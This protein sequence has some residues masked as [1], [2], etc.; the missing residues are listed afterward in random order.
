MLPEL[1]C[2]SAGISRLTMQSRVGRVS[3]ISTTTVQALGLSDEAKLGDETKIVR[4]DGSSII[5]EI[6]AMHGDTITVLPEDK[7]K[8]LSIGDRVYLVG[9][10]GIFP[11]ESWLGRV[12]DPR[13]RPLDGRPLSNGAFSV[14]LETTPPP[15]ALRR[16]LGVRKASGLLAMDTV[17]PVV[18]GQ[19]M[20]LFAGSGVGKSMM[21]GRL[22]QSM[23]AD[24]AVVAL[25]G[26]RGREVQEFVRNTL[27][28]SGMTRSV[29]VAAT[30]D[31]PALM[32]RKCIKT[33][34]AVAEYFRDAGQQVLFLADSITRFAEAHREIATAAGEPAT[35]RGFPA[36]TS[37]QIMQLCER[38]GPGIGTSGDITAIMTVLVEGGDFD[39]PVADIVRGV[40]DGHVVLSRDIAERGRYPAI[41][42]LRSVS[43]SLPL[44]ASESE[45]QMITEVRT[46][47]GAYERSEALVRS[48]LYS[49]GSDPVLDRAVALW[50]KIDA[51]LGE[52]TEE[53]IPESFLKLRSCLA[54][55]SP[56]I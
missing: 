25:I 27:G 42:L 21:L 18:Q 30:S 39:G 6:V 44:A 53:T 50:P 23:E 13:G 9:D 35:L 41:D 22:A 10:Y 29:V 24:I 28:E 56:Q 32:R 2:L 4:K 36:S 51:F 43:R 55:S 54:S 31:T 12:V 14:P 7:P 26:E 40:L 45:N 47:L 15:A 34:M 19:R 1:E 11:D 46:L 48:G 17:L 38:A 16:P 33:A 52:T 8:R 5:A 49:P 37:Q 3:A 20:G